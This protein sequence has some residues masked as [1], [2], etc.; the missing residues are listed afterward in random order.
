M[1]MTSVTTTRYSLIYDLPHGDV[2]VCLRRRFAQTKTIHLADEL[3]RATCRWR[4]SDA[5]QAVTCEGHGNNTA[6]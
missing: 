6:R 5:Q 1:E 2:H 3:K 4:E